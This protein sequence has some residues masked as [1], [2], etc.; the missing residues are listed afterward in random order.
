MT[1][2]VLFL[3]F[4][5]VRVSIYLLICVS[6]RGYWRRLS[7]Y[8][9]EVAEDTDHYEACVY[10]EE[11]IQCRIDVGHLVVC[12]IQVYKSLRENIRSEL[13]NVLRWTDAHEAKITKT[14]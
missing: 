1:A 9:C 2:A 3:Y 10:R 6:K 11:Q 13:I 12:D 5:E 14:T 4:E 7:G 8:I